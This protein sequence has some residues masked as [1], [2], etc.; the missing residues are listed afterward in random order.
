VSAAW[1]AIRKAAPREPARPFALTKLRFPHALELTVLQEIR[2]G[3]E[4]N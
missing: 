3:P 4:R 1:R 2:I